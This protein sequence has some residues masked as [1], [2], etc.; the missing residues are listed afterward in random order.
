M[1]GGIIG[2]FFFGIVGVQHEGGIK[3]IFPRKR[4]MQK[5]ACPPDGSGQEKNEFVE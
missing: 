4:K 1:Q 2:L 3:V 5:S